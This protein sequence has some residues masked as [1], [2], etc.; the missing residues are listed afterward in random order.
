MV[1]GW[2]HDDV[3][4]AMGKMVCLIHPREKA[5][6]SMWI[7]VV[8]KKRATYWEHLHQLPLSLLRPPARV[9]RLTH[10]TTSPSPILIP[11]MT[12]T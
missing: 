8:Q 5:W 3:S 12:P 4:G 1:A 10:S 6:I 2:K 7:C 9:E 11:R